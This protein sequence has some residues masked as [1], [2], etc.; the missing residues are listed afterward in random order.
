MMSAL[1]RQG[2]PETSMRADKVDERDFDE[3]I[4][5]LLAYNLVFPEKNDATSSQQIE[6][7]PSKVPITHNELSVQYDCCHSFLY[8]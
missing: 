2:V 3:A 6:S 1:D 5:T 7:I 8:S 4:G